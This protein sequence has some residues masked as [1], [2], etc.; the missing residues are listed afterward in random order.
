MR[1]SPFDTPKY[2]KLMFTT[3]EF[4]SKFGSAYEQCR[5]HCLAHFTQLLTPHTPVGKPYTTFVG[6]VR[7]YMSFDVYQRLSSFYC[8]EY[9]SV[10]K[11]NRCKLLGSPNDPIT[12]SFANLL[13]ILLFLFTFGFL[14]G[15][16]TG[17]ATAS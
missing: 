1:F 16:S 9:Y 7:I 15:S 11:N 4:L 17:C 2:D 14:V 10:T 8:L 6:N 5:Y 3:T 12:R 13:I